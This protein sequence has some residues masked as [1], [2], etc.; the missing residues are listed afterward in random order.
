MGRAGAEEWERDE[1]LRKYAEQHQL[2]IEHANHLYTTAWDRFRD[3]PDQGLAI[4]IEQLYVDVMSKP[5]FD[6]DTGRQIKAKA[7]GTLSKVLL[8]LKRL[9]Q[10]AHVGEDE[11]EILQAYVASLRSP[12]PALR[13]ALKQ[14]GYVARPGLIPPGRRPVG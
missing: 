1:F 6:D 8:D 14:V 9:Q 12:N 11:K 5:T 7:K 3:E 13:K 10:G 2:D 4:C